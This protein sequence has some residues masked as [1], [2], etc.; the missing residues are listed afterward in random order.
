ML[1]A[2][3][4]Q[5]GRRL[6]ILSEPDT[7]LSGGLGPVSLQARSGLGGGNLVLLDPLVVVDRRLVSK[8]GSLLV[9][10]HVFGLLLNWDV[11]LLLLRRQERSVY[12]RVNQVVLFTHGV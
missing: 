10:E 7:A 11:L 8:L 4:L 6:G 3:V 12:F 1:N 9:E 5:A 2:P